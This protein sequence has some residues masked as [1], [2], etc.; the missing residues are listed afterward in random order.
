[1][2]R[3]TIKG[4]LF[5]IIMLSTISSF[6]IIC[7]VYFSALSTMGKKNIEN[8]MHIFLGQV[9]SYFDEGYFNLVNIMQNLE[10][11][12][13]T[14]GTVVSYLTETDSYEKAVK[15]GEMDQEIA[16]TMFTN[17]N[18]E[19]I[20]YFDSVKD[21]FVCG[22][23]S[24]ISDYCSAKTVLKTVGD[25]TFFAAD[26]N[27]SDRDQRLMI[28]IIKE[29]QNFETAKLDIYVEQSIE[30]SNNLEYDL[31]QV[32]GDGIVCYSESDS[33][34][35]GTPLN[36]ATDS[37]RS[38]Q[39][40]RQ[41]E[42]FLMAAQ[43][44]MGVYYALALPISL[45]NYEVRQWQWRMAAVVLISLALFYCAVMAIYQMIVKPL[46]KLNREIER[47]GKGNF[48]MIADDTSIEEFHQIMTAMN[49]MK[50]DIQVLQET[51][52]EEQ[53]KSEKAEIEKLMY[54]INP[55]FVL[56]TLYS[57]QW[58][59][60]KSGNIELREFVHNLMAILSYNLGKEKDVSTLR[61]EIEIAKRYVDIQRQRYDFDIRM[62]IEDGSW[63]DAP[64]IR[65]LLQPLIE[66][67]LQHGLGA[68]GRLE[69]WIFHD[70][71]SH[72]GV[73]IV[74]DHGDGLSKEKLLELNLPLGA[75]E[76]ANKRTGIGL[77]YVRSVLETF[78][79]GQALL[80]VNSI[81]GGGTTVT[82]LIPLDKGKEGT[83][84]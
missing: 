29:Q 45:Y 65:M 68:C 54:Q 10:P 43:S 58:M 77:R 31:L 81:L 42:H 78:Y 14:G 82:I 5:Q 17:L 15:K 25:H 1:M 49:Q 24:D 36:I 26:R 47:T 61:T 84:T 13:E 50:Q 18:I 46:R 62:E 64:T 60:Q 53:K 80:H 57:I 22:N 76:T 8:S 51:K 55:H 67:T 56:N 30:L 75:D 79:K 48:E 9:V 11:G 3:T 19:K 20:S 52:L 73:I 32:N 23:I 70:P 37:Q 7:L 39:I 44:K 4:K 40:F 34:E 21:H 27:S 33:F 2:K 41:R 83:E 28:S 59:A 74:R 35:R 71:I 6:L 16:D 12:G 69:L 63:L 38:Y 66:N 72:Y